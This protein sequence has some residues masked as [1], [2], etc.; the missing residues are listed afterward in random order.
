MSRPS[1][2]LTKQVGGALKQEPSKRIAEMLADAVTHHRAGRLAEAQQLYLQILALDVRHADSLHLLGM[3]EHELGHSQ[4]AIKMVQRAIASNA[5]NA[6]YHSNLSTIFESQA[7]HE[8]AVVAARRAIELQPD[9]SA[10]HNN[11]GNALRSQGRLDEAIASYK[12]AMEL[13]PNYPEACHNLGCVFTAQNKH[14]EA[15]SCF[16]RA[17]ELKPDYADA[18][19]SFGNSLRYQNK[20]DDAISKFERALQF[21][22]NY[23]EAYCNLGIVR[24]A[25]NRMDEAVVCYKQALALRPDYPDVYNNLGNAYHAQN[26]LDEAVTC[27]ERALALR[28]IYPE[29]INNLAGTL[30][31][32]GKLDEAVTC[33]R[34]ALQINPDCADAYF[35][36][37][38]VQLLRGDFASGWPLYE[39][40]WRSLDCR[41]D[42]KAYSQPRWTGEKLASGQLLIWGEQGIGDEII[43]AGLVLEAVRR[44][45]RCV[46]SCDKR[47]QPLFARSFSEVQVIAGEV[48]GCDPDLEIAAQ[49]PSGSL[50]GLLRTTFA[51]FAA[52]TSPYLFA[53]PLVRQKLRASYSDGRRVVGVAWYTSNRMTGQARS[54]ALS[55]LAPLFAR[56]DIRWVSLQYGNHDALE[57]Q[58]A[59]AGVPLFV[60]RSVDQFQDMDLFAAQIA[61][62]D[63]VITIDNS[64]AHL[65]GALGV[66]TWVLLPYT[67]DWRW[68]LHRE[69]SPWYPSVR[70][71]R[72]QKTGD[73]Q[74]VLRQVESALNAFSLLQ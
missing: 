55:S 41:T 16:E 33:Y 21:R 40:R 17:L 59:E 47:L 22:S 71:F 42:E 56:S 35:H 19:N 38:L 63:L 23:P 31:A 50:P 27:Y 3:I 69:D 8:E 73:W 62:M 48:P 74:P 70:L 60:D 24:K 36:L 14:D 37:S 61:A 30:E 72:Q 32:Q 7:L 11:L 58:A 29:A 26:K 12:R 52:A 4:S 1:I 28:P 46:L 44:G 43:F 68:F 65:A 18:Y 67:P 20:L 57:A 51:G 9:F 53:D 2:L 45:N 13:N 6:V 66:P 64:T 15:D 34:R 25:Q 10:A 49:L 54:I 39:W 5:K